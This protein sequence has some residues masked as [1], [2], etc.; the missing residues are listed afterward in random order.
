MSQKVKV[1]SLAAE[2]P[3]PDQKG[4]GPLQR[5]IVPF[6]KLSEPVQETLQRKASQDDLVIFP[7]ATGA[8]QKTVTDGLRNARVHG[9]FSV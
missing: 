6:W 2:R 4:K 9:A 5:E 7:R 1:A 8:P 3:F